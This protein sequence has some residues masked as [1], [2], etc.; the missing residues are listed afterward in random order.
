LLVLSVKIE[1]VVETKKV[2]A[3]KERAAREE[4]IT[5]INFGMSG[6]FS[7]TEAK[8]LGAIW[9]SEELDPAVKVIN[10]ELV[11]SK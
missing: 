1:E 4:E 3:Y 9:A 2:R 10:L 7:V 11:E 6:A 5:Q 8:T